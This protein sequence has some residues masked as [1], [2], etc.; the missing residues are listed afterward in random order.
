MQNITSIDELRNA[1]QLLEVEQTLKGKLL[2]EQFFL[3]YESFKP[4]NF[5]TKTIG[6]MAKSPLLANTL[7][8]TGLF[9]ASRLLTKLVF[10]GTT[11]NK[12]QKLIGNILQFGITDI[13]TRNSGSIKSLVSSLFGRFFSRNKM[14]TEKP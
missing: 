6:N 9:L 4:V 10:I 14:N 11:G 1:I 13:V 5:I 2:K 3:T 12:M 7:L 8:G